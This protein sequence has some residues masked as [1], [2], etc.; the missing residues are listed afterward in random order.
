ML[1]Q[2]FWSPHPINF[3]FISCEEKGSSQESHNE[4]R[5]LVLSDP[6]CWE[7][8]CLTWNQVIQ[9]EFS[10]SDIWDSLEFTKREDVACVSFTFHNRES[11]R[12]RER[13]EGDNSF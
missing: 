7:L 9:N 11:E 6:I 10:I 13:S 2:P 8:L 12:E 3:P 1:S 4:N 5:M